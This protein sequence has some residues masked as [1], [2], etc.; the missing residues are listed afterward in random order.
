V[1]STDWRD[2]ATHGSVWAFDVDGTLIGSI[3]SDVLR[4]GAN[5]LLEALGWLGVSCIL[6]SAGGKDYAQRMA[7]RH[8]I[9][10]AFVAF[11]AK[12]VRDVHSRY[13][14]VHVASE[15]RPHVF[16]DDVPTDLP[17]DVPVLSVPQFMGGNPADTA[18]S[19]VLEQ[20]TEHLRERDSH[21]HP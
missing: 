13:T 20:L 21:E 18:F 12:D 14:V 4:P 17:S 19:S 2:H 5:E 10:E 15:H 7:E 6:W 8:G 9:A 16:V 1:V 11:Y 3:R